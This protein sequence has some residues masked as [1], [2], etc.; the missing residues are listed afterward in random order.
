MRIL[1][2]ARSLAGLVVVVATVGS[3]AVA[4]APPDEA[5]VKAAFLY[6]FLKFVEWPP[7]VF[8]TAQDSLIV[9]IVGGGSTADAAARFLDGKP[10][11]G[12]AV[13]IRRLKDEG[14]RPTVHALF[15]GDADASRARRLLEAVA[16]AAVLSIGEREDFAEDGGV[17]GL[18]VEGQKVRFEINT[19]AAAT[20]G[21]KISSKLLALARI[22]HATRTD[23][24]APR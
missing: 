8:L 18:M 5:Q 17:I 9:G 12:R 1:C 10:V 16:N 21:L 19:D 24:A 7:E 3:V 2:G 6:N 23:Q 14:L 15:I 22:V 11:Q 4:Q 20:A 13:A